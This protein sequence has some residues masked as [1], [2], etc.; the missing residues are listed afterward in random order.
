MVLEGRGQLALAF[1]GQAP[2]VATSVA[3]RWLAETLSQRFVAQSEALLTQ[4]LPVPAQRY[5][6]LRVGAA[7][8]AWC[9]PRELRVGDCLRLEAG[10]VVP[11]D[12]CVLHGE[13][14]LAPVLPGSA[15]HPVGAGDAVAAGE[16]LQRGALELRAEADADHSR[17]ARLQHQLRHLL[18]ARPLAEAPD[19]SGGLALPLTAA[20]LV[21]GLTGDR[22]RAAALLQADPQQG[23]D[24]A[25][26]VAREA[27]LLAL[28]RQ[29]LLTT[30]PDTLLRLARASVVL[31]E[32]Q[33]VLSSARWTLESVQVR[34]GSTAA[35]LRAGLAQALGARE[36]E[37]DL[38]LP[39]GR[40]R[41]WCRHGALLRVGP[42]EVQLADAERLQRIWGLQLPLPAW[43]PGAPPRRVLA[44]VVDGQVLAH[45]VFVSPWREELGAPLTQLAGLGIEHFAFYGTEAPLN[46]P[47]AVL[48]RSHGLAS[49]WLAHATEGG[50]RPA[51]LL[52]RTLR[53]LVPPGSLSL[54]PL[55]AE[56]GAHGLLVGEPLARLVAARQM[57]QRIQRQL[58]WR[59]EFAVGANAALMTLGA[60][61]LLSPMA[62]ALMHHGTALALLLHSLRLEWA[63]VPEPDP[64]IQPEPLEETQDHED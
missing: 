3:L 25:R 51:L 37:G 31:V 40:L 62:T 29:G 38:H 44:C 5:L 2:V 57:A 33:G 11:V 63:A 49:D 24:L 39:D 47:G 12:A 22:A 19:V 43:E 53:D 4:L 58:R 23:P 35:P 64:E 15:A 18:A 27:A 9:A 30:G 21:L 28:A 46:H 7:E 36:E 1:S 50:R 14:R 54:S 26:P 41:E 20:A 61:R 55:D 10:D 17:L 16:R 48:L 6:V 32:V 34:D 42:H 13:A 60:L 45:L 52:H 59:D 56:G 8:A